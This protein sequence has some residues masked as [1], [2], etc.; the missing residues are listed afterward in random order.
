MLRF[1]FCN[2]IKTFTPHAKSVKGLDA[3][4]TQLGN[5]F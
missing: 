5:R 4:A 2:A 3:H 1:T